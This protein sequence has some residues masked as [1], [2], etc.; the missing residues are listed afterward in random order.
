MLNYTYFVFVIIREYINESSFV[1]TFQVKVKV[2]SEVIK[3]F[4]Q[5]RSSE[6]SEVIIYRSNKWDSLLWSY[7][8]VTTK[9]I[10]KVLTMH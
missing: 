6:C 9:G 2:C 8:K 5:L 1:N 3:Y 7:L 4:K 10:P